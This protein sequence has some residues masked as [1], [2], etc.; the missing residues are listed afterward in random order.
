LLAQ[1]RSGELRIART[2]KECADIDM[3]AIE[4]LFDATMIALLSRPF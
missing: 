3:A 1:L 4:E 2:F